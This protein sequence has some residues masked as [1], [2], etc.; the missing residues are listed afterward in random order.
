M[1]LEHRPRRRQLA[2]GLLL[3]GL[4]GGLFTQVPTA[5]AQ[6]RPGTDV[7]S[8][9]SLD[10]LIQRGIELRRSGKDSEALRVF[11]EA[12]RVERHSIRLRVHLASTHQALGHWLEAD[13][14][15]QGVLAEA[16]DAYVTRHR[17]TLERAADFVGRHIGSVEV[18][19]EPAGAEVRL[20]GELLGTLPLPTT[21]TLVGS[22]E[23]QVTRSGYYEVRRPVVVGPRGVVRESVNLA[24]VVETPA[25]S[26]RAPA[27]REA[28]LGSGSPRW[29]SWALT[30]ASAGALL[31]TG[32]S[33]YLREQ[34]ASRWNSNDCLEVGRLRGDVCAT[35]L[36]DGRNAERV[37]YV[38]GAATLLLGVGAIVSW[39]L[40]EPNAPAA[41]S[42][43][44]NCG[45]TLGGA[46]CSGSF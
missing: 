43:A 32:V 35:E 18:T 2:F 8:S 12:E 13:V 16:A 11:E 42:L 39:T 7:E 31:T 21:R 25:R 23:L 6:S 29:L 44:A 30:G 14:Y 5:Q 3:C 1:A 33:L 4:S 45:M 27:V 22:Y 40:D 37:A 34:R 17:A 15:L 41:A 20:N 19:G 10:R 36:A 46:V 24:S 26:P 9:S 38:S 28:D